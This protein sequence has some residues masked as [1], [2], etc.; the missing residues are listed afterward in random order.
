MPTEEEDIDLTPMIDVTFL[1][2]IFFMVTSLGVR[3]QLVNLPKAAHADGEPPSGLMTI[4]MAQ[5]GSVTL[6]SHGR[7]GAAQQTPANL[8]ELAQTVRDLPDQ[9]KGNLILKA[10]LATKAEDVSIVMEAL[11]KAGVDRIKIGVRGEE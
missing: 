11:A 6:D 5:D 2:L 7:E 8:D 4:H 3:P 10:D 9:R 1:L